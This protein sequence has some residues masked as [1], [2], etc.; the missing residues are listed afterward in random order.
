MS[1]RDIKKGDELTWNY[2]DA[3]PTS[4]GLIGK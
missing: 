3:D 1:V 4:Q 2:R